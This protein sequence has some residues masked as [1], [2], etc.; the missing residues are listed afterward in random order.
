[1]RGKRRSEPVLVLP[2]GAVARLEFEVKRP[3]VLVS[4]VLSQAGEVV[5]EEPAGSDALIDGGVH[6]IDLDDGHNP[7][8]GSIMFET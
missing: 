3:E 8:D 1:M 6:R 2:P 7:D 4:W 5:V